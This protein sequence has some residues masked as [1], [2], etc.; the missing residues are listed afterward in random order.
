ML[1]TFN[2]I[3]DELVRKGDIKKYIIIATTNIIENIDTSVL[4]RFYFH[5]DFNN[6][7]DSNEFEKYFNELVKLTESSKLDSSAIN[8]IYKLYCEKRY[9][10]GEVKSIFAHSFFDSIALRKSKN[11]DIDSFIKSFK[12]KKTFH[13][14]ATK[15]IKGNES[16]N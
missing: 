13:E 11:L 4:R 14:I 3:I 9:T 12:N 10:L 5:E 2:T 16:A 7:L 1:L 15:Q 8:D 6:N